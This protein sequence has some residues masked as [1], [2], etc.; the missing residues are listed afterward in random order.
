M[1]MQGMWIVQTHGKDFNTILISLGIATT[2]GGVIQALRGMQKQI[3]ELKSAAGTAE[4]DTADNR[5][6]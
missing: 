5:D 3:D 2:A 4:A 6:N 1:I